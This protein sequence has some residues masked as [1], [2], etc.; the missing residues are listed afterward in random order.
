MSTKTF[1]SAVDVPATGVTGRGILATMALLV[2][3]VSE[4]REAEG[5][6]RGL[7]VHGMSPAEAAAETFRRHYKS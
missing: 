5:C 7:T 2:A 1:E 3:A 4:G 6:Y